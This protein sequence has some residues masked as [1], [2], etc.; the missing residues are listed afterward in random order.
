M[1]NILL[2]AFSLLLLCFVNSCATGPKITELC[3][4][5][6]VE[7]PVVGLPLTWEFRGGTMYV[8][9]KEQITIKLIEDR[10]VKYYSGIHKGWNDSKYLNEIEGPLEILISYA[11]GSWA[12]SEMN[13]KSKIIIHNGRI[14]VVGTINLRKSQSYY[15][16][17]NLSINNAML[18]HKTLHDFNKQCLEQISWHYEIDRVNDY[19]IV[20]APVKAEQMAEIYICNT[21]L[22]FCSKIVK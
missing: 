10:N 13:E 1:K 9:S 11:G 8:M 7:I 21:D 15:K 14:G 16:G 19:Y 17:E 22:V 3:F 18:I 12:K 2:I 4:L 5:P 6:N 20:K